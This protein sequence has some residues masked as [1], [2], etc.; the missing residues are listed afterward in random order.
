[1]KNIVFY[2]LKDTKLIASMYQRDENIYKKFI[3]EK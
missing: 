2:T 1:M 3:N